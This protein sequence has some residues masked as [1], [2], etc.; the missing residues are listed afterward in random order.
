MN[1]GLSRICWSI[2]FTVSELP[3]ILIILARYIFYGIIATVTMIHSIKTI[4]HK[5]DKKAAITMLKPVITGNIA[6]YLLLTKAVLQES[7]LHL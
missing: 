3:N 7:F 4:F 1:I 6:Y 5:I 2:V